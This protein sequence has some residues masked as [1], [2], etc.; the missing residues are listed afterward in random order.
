[1]LQDDQTM[2]TEV[3]RMA[4]AHFNKLASLSVKVQGARELGVL[5]AHSSIGESMIPTEFAI[6]KMAERWARRRSIQ[7]SHVDFEKLSSADMEKLGALAYS[8]LGEAHMEKLAAGVLD[9][10]ITWDE[11]SDMEKLAVGWLGKA[12]GGAKKL[13]TTATKGRTPTLPKAP[14]VPG[15]GFGAGLKQKAQGAWDV[16]SG[17]GKSVPGTGAAPKPTAAQSAMREVQDLRRADPAGGA[18]KMQG[19]SGVPKTQAQSGPYREAAPPPPSAPKHTQGTGAQAAG[20]TGKAGPSGQAPDLPAPPPSDAAPTKRAPLLSTK[21]KLLLGGTAAMGG[22][23]YLGGKALDTAN[24]FLT[25]Q[26][27]GTAYQYGGGSPSHF[28]RPQMGM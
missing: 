12:I 27:P 5:A 14:K 23:T 15:E 28:M 21:T 19:G 8:E 25:P 4:R 10:S 16:M 20:T 26:P 18:R 6:E 7:H 1:M 24:T 2:A 22:A 3:T 13:L 11:L 17:K 9:G